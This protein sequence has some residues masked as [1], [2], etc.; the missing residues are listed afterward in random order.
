MTIQINLLPWREQ[1][2]RIKK[3]KFLLTLSSFIILTLLM[4]VIIH[5][6]Y[7]NA[8]SSQQDLTVFLQKKISDSQIQYTELENTKKE[9]D[10][11]R[12]KII[13]LMNLQNSIWIKY[14]CPFRNL[15]NNSFSAVRLFNILP[16]IIP[17]NIS[18]LKLQRVDNII[19]LQG[20]AFTNLDITALMKKVT[21]SQVLV[22][23]NLTEIS[24]QNLTAEDERL[25]ELKLVLKE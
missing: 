12:K 21:Q 13:F 18:L 9:Q 16:K 23:P 5:V 10:I 19:N 25:F 17:S 24:S 14:S 7:K 4:V 15:Q 1:E 2:R 20:V 11:T 22:Q 6:F 8:I 3:I